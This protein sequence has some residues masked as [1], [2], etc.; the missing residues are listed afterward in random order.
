[1]VGGEM[2]T[3]KERRAKR[4][5]RLLESMKK[6]IPEIPIISGSEY[7]SDVEEISLEQKKREARENKRIFVP[8]KKEKKSSPDKVLQNFMSDRTSLEAL[9]KAGYPIT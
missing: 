5:L 3:G 2:K 6:A 8:V 7:L 4:K 1:M 9:K